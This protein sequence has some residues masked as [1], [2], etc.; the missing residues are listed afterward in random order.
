MYLFKLYQF[1]NFFLYLHSSICTDLMSAFTNI[2]DIAERIF[3]AGIP[4]WFMRV[5]Y[6]PPF[7]LVLTFT[8]LQSLTIPHAVLPLHIH[9]ASKSLSTRV[10]EIVLIIV[11]SLHMFYCFLSYFHIHFHCSMSGLISYFTLCIADFMSLCISISITLCSLSDISFL[12][13]STSCM[14]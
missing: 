4:V 5:C 13:C 10:V 1:D 2:S 9:S 11:L 12:S 14:L 6:A 3:H 8:E 7:R